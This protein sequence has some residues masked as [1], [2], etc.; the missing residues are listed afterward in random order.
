MGRREGQKGEVREGEMNYCF[1][2]AH[3]NTMTGTKGVVL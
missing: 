2:M 1:H 3:N